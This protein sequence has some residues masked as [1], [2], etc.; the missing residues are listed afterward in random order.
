VN[1]RA[2]GPDAGFTLVELLVAV[3]VAALVVGGLAEV[4]GSVLHN[5]DTTVTRVEGSGSAFLTGAR[6]GDDVSASEAIG[7]AA[8]VSRGAVGCGGDAS[9]VV[10]FLSSGND[11]DQAVVVTSY[12]VTAEPALER[13]VCAGTDLAAAL[14]ADP[15]TITVVPH[16]AT[17]ATPVTVACRAT[18]GA[19]PAPATPAGDAQ[20]RIVTLTVSTPGGYT[21]TLKSVRSVTSADPSSPLL[22]QCTLVV[23]DDANVYQDQPDRNFND[24]D[25]YGESPGGRNFIEDRN[26]DGKVIKGYFRFNLAGPCDGTAAGEPAFRPPQRALTSAT[27]RLV[28]HDATQ[29]GSNQKCNAQHNIDVLA[30]TWDPATLTWN[31]SPVQQYPADGLQPLRHGFATTGSWVD[32]PV[33]VDVLAE[34]RHWYPAPGGG[35]WANQGWVVSDMVNGCDDH[36]S[37]KF[38]SKGANNALSPRLVLTWT[39]P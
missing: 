1:G 15:R 35:D 17:G 29:N 25:D 18:S 23:T 13:R 16:L 26:K 33:T 11:A 9:S 10:R 4:L 14:A 24:R 30:R 12:S 20:C 19:S 39:E 27:L 8:A 21:F 7:A 31:N 3:I 32:R 38:M 22:W 2:P 6:F 28:F 37:N 5:T 36:E 34:V